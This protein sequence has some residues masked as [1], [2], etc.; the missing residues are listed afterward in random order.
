MRASFVRPVSAPGLPP[1]ITS[2]DD[3]MALGGATGPVDRS[4]GAA[5]PFVVLTLGGSVA[6]VG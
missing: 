2:V 3:E 6:A 5:P 4:A 1:C